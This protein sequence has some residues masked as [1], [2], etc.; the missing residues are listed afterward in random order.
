MR[1]SSSRKSMH[2]IMGHTG[3]SQLTVKHEG[4]AFTVPSH[5]ITK[6]GTLKKIALRLIKDCKTA[7]DAVELSKLGF[8]I[9]PA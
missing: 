1:I 6:G 9:T 7:D 3:F 5:C 8:S 2:S 4:M